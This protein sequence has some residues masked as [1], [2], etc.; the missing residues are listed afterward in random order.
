MLEH[1]WNTAGEQASQGRPGLEGR[2]G[3]RGGIDDDAIRIEQP[4]AYGGRLK[5]SDA[6]AFCRKNQTRF[7]AVGQAGEAATSQDSEPLG[8][9]RFI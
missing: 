3:Q 6:P 8:G 1:T 7:R 9:R 2:I 5:M 4:G